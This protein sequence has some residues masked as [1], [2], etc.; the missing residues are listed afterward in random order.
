MGDLGLVPLA[1]GHISLIWGV[2]LA[3]TGM[4]SSTDS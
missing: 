4:I 1:S 3:S 2:S